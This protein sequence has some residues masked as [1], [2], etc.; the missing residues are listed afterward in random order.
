MGDFQQQILYFWTTNFL[1]AIFQQEIDFLTVYN[2][3]TGISSIC[4]NCPNAAHHD[5][6]AA[7]DLYEKLV[8]QNEHYE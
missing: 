3:H 1:T 8:S 6:T 7:S 4:S 5:A 2:M